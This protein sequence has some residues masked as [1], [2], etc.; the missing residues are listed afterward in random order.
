MRT[1]HGRSCGAGLLAVVL[2]VFPVWVVLLACGATSHAALVFGNLHAAE[3]FTGYGVQDDLTINGV[4]LNG[5]GAGLGMGFSGTWTA[6][7]DWK[8][9]IN[10]NRDLNAQVPSSGIGGSGGPVLRANVNSGLS[11]NAF[12]GFATAVTLPTNGLRTE[13]WL[14]FNTYNRSVANPGFVGLA[15]AGG[16]VWV[17]AG[18][19]GYSSVSNAHFPPF[20]DQNPGTQ[21]TDDEQKFGIKAFSYSN[22]AIAA[23][24]SSTFNAQDT[25]HNVVLR[26]LWADDGTVDL[27]L[28]LNP[29]SGD[30][31]T[32]FD[33]FL[34]GAFIGADLTRLNVVQGRVAHWVAFDDIAV[35]VNIIPEPGS[36]LLLSGGLVLLV[37]RRRRK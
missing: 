31:L 21:P 1:K 24:T 35:Y 23:T 25:W 10:V 29:D 37:T 2:R 26:G 13:F 4:N 12:R 6:T 11:N 30:D 22:A 9:D 7:G 20:S 5:T 16:K 28:W 3:D 15:D 17:E 32:S 27:W 8:T 18:F 34:G 14:V 19:T 36:L 33:A